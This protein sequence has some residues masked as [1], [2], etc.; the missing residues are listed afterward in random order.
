MLGIDE[1]EFMKAT[2]GSFKL[3]IE[4]VDWARRGHRYFHPFGPHGRSFDTVPLHQY[5]L[6]AHMAGDTTPIDDYSMAWAIAREGRFSHPS[7]DQRS[8]LSTFD[9]AYHFDAGLYARYLRGYSEQRGVVRIEG[10]IADVSLNGETGFVSGVTMEDGRRIEA[11]LFID[12]SGFRGPADR[13]RAQGR[14]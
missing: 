12:C 5:W 4:F 8:V 9:Y 14:L 6:R 10:K 7:P 1:R 3:G 2:Q 13:R 11:E